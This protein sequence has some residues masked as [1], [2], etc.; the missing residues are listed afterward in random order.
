MV[1][2]RSFDTAGYIDRPNHLADRRVPHG[3]IFIPGK[4]W[5][6]GDAL[7]WQSDF[8]NCK[9]RKPA[10][11]ILQQFIT[12]RRSEDSGIEGFA[13][14]WGPLRYDPAGQS[15]DA[16]HGSEPL[17][18]WRFLSHRAYA[19]LNCAAE[20]KDGI[21]AAEK[22]LG[23]ISTRQEST[24]WNPSLA[25]PEFFGF[26]NWARREIDLDAMKWG[27]ARWGKK[28][29]ADDMRGVLAGELTFWLE[30]FPPQLAMSWNRPKNWHLEIRYRGRVLPAIALQLALTV[31]GGD[32]YVC[33][34]CHE[35]YIRAGRRRPNSGQQNYCNDC[36]LDEA[37]R[38]A[39]ER[40]RVKKAEARRLDRRG[41]AP[42]EIAKRLN[43][44]R[45][46]V[47]RWTKKGT[48]GQ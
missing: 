36:G 8:D 9:H 19:V 35:P 41:A 37:R 30:R 46:T 38:K 7:K 11:S 13:K 4:I 6:E 29:G 40:R 15:V 39:D 22:H 20:L 31:S 43:T 12:L 3:E 26:P 45:D 25:Q 5:I 32:L 23:L 42:D 34:G 47:K 2:P 18:Y 28:L 33:D 27:A 16:D 44:S 21:S 17:A 48:H 10:G 14:R 24:E 1:L